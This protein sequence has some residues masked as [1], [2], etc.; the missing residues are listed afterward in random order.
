VGATK[1][2]VVKRTKRCAATSV[3]PL[4]AERDINIPGLIARTY[5]HPDCGVYAEVVSD[6]RIAIGDRVRVA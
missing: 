5:R 1:L 4:T 3:N 6:G 2:R